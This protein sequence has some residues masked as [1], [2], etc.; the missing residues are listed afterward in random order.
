MGESLA[1][2]QCSEDETDGVRAQDINVFGEK[3]EDQ[4]GNQVKI[5]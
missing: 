3:A 5:Q 2:N 4:A 1:L